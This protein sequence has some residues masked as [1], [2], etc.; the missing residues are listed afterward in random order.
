MKLPLWLKALVGTY[1]VGL[2][3]VAA[4][5]GN[6]MALV[7]ISVIAATCLGLGVYVGY[8]AGVSRSAG[9]VTQLEEDLA[10]QQAI[11]AVLQLRAG[12]EP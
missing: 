2:L 9:R 11:S 10:I 12:D 8:G 3:L 5:G 7:S 4:F 6:W 1:F